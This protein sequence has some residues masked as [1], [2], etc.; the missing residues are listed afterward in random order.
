MNTVQMPFTDT[1]HKISL[2]ENAMEN[3]ILE[4][5]DFSDYVADA[6]AW[7][8]RL[9]TSVALAVMVLVCTSPL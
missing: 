3:L 6:A 7:T 4:Q 2:G 9:S 5:T 1:H 8:S